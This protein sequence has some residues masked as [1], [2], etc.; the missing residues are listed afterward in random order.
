MQRS[1][2]FPETL[3]RLRKQRGS[4]SALA[5]EIGVSRVTL[6]RWEQGTKISRL[7]RELLGFKFPGEFGEERR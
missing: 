7:H 5:R 1:R 2:T 4:R 3:A 6:W